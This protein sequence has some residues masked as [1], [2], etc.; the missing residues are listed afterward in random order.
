MDKGKNEQLKRHSVINTQTHL[1]NKRSKRNFW[2]VFITLVITGGM[3]LL[4]IPSVSDS[5]HNLEAQSGTSETADLSL[6]ALDKL[7]LGTW[8]IK[9]W[10]DPVEGL[11]QG[12]MSINTK[13]SDG[14]F[15]GQMNIFAGSDGR[16]IKQNISLRLLS[17][18]EVEIQGKVTEG[19][20]WSND[21]FVLNINRDQLEGGG[22]DRQGNH[23]KVIFKKVP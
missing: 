20:H 6:K 15:Q 1:K 5:Q 12:T 17:D 18:Q 10:N 2:A 7:I 13:V 14:M 22:D 8:D 4:L 19:E 3:I 9:N 21:Y 23:Q 11:N 16:L